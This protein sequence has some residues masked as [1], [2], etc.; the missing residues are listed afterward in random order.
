MLASEGKNKLAF[1]E[2]KEAF[3][4]KIIPLLEE[5]FY[6]DWNKIRLVL[7]DS[8]KN[9]ESLRFLDGHEDLYSDLFGGEHGLELYEEKKITYKIKPFHCDDAVWDDAKA[10]TGIYTIG[11]NE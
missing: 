4:N 8:L 6:E 10:Y 5:Y 1:T 9:D 3:K 11:I 7:G 2:L